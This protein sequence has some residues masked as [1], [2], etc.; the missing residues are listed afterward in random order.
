M[1]KESTKQSTKPKEEPTEE[2]S[3]V[4]DESEKPTAPPPFEWSASS[5]LE[6]K[7]P[8]VPASDDWFEDLEALLPSPKIA[9]EELRAPSIELPIDDAAEALAT[10]SAVP[11]AREGARRAA[12]N[13][14]EAF[15][16]MLVDGMTSCKEI[17]AVCLLPRAR[18]TAALAA[19]AR[20]GALYIDPRVE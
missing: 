11:R 10:C 2:E 6:S 7:T 9:R 3:R 17:V 16:L 13:V 5:S 14:D 4:L 18:T 20:R 1:T 19:L 12:R 8:M 15:V